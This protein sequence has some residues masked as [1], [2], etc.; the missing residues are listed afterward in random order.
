MHLLKSIDEVAYQALHEDLGDGDL[1]ANLLPEDLQSKARLITREDA[2]LCGTCWFDS[3]FKQLDKNID[4][5]WHVKDG[6]DISEN[7]E[8][9]TLQGPARALLTG[10]RT[11]MNFIQT[12]SGTATIAREYA[13]ALEGTTTK[14]LDTRKTIPGLREAQKYAVRSGGGYNHRLGLFDGIL[15]KENHIA[16]SGSIGKAV[17]TA[18]E[19]YPETPVEVEVETLGE[20]KE[21]IGAS[22]DIIML[23]NFSLTD[24]RKAVV[25]TDGRARLE[26]SGGFDM[27]TLRETAETGV[28]YISVG[29][30]TKHIRALDLSMRFII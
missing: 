12:L 28:D 2:V 17:S 23:D 11:A 3:V 27:K 13:K 6:D 1:T 15:L 30:L 9:C 7:Q 20:L 5:Q 19:R 10:E 21:A 24:M 25:I 14:L 22:A 18:K 26:A 4:I 29:A 16:A 8:L